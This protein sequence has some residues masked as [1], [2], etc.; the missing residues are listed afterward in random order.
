MTLQAA[1]G[2]QEGFGTPGTLASR[3]HNPGNIIKGEF[4]ILHGAFAGDPSPYAVFASDVMGWAALTALLR[5]PA[6]ATLT[7]E[8]AINK[9]CPVGAGDLARGNE[10]SIYVRNVCDW[11]G[12]APD[13]PIAGLLG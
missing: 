9:Y 13:T 2:H 3:N 11:C 7:V 12:C 10:P 6:Y 1:I 8:Q 4:A 5:T